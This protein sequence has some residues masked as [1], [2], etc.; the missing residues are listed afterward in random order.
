MAIVLSRFELRV[1]DTT[2]F[3]VDLEL[4][5]LIRRP[6]AGEGLSWGHRRYGAESFNGRRFTYSYLGRYGMSCFTECTNYSL[7]LSHFFPH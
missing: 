2:I 3:E 4:L 1:E 5:E 6:G 7:D